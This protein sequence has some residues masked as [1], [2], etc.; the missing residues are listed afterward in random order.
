MRG[1]EPNHVVREVVVVVQKEDVILAAQDLYPLKDH[2]V[3]LAEVG[4]GQFL[5][6][7]ILLPQEVDLDRR[8]R[9]HHHLKLHL[10]IGNVVVRAEMLPQMQPQM[11]SMQPGKTEL[12]HL[13][14]PLQGRGPDRQVK[15]QVHQFQ[16]QLQREAVKK[17]VLFGIIA[18]KKKVDKV[19]SS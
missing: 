18:N 17:Q 19:M 14:D 4:H 1:K 3:V 12:D 16:V 13:L 15:I 5:L 11:L 10:L 9:R 8:F 7:Q 6:P 2:V